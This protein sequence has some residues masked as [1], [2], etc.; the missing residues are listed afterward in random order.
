MPDII[1]M[2]P[3]GRAGRLSSGEM[4]WQQQLSQFQGAA[5]LMSKNLARHQQMGEAKLKQAN[6]EAKLA[7]Q[8][9]QD[10]LAGDMYLDIA[11]QRAQMTPQQQESETFFKT[12][13]HIKDPKLRK[14]LTDEHY[15]LQKQKQYMQAAE[16]GVALLNA[17]IQDGYISESDG[18]RILTE[19]EAKVSKGLDISATLDEID[20]LKKKAVSSIRQERAWS[21][22]G[23]AMRQLVDRMP[24]GPEKEA[25]DER[26]TAIENFPS[27]RTKIDPET[28]IVEM[29]AGGQRG[30]TMKESTGSFG[31]PGL[32]VMNSLSAIGEM[33]EYVTKSGI[34]A[35]RPNLPKNL[36]G[37][38]RLPNKITF[39]Q[40]EEAIK[41]A[42]GL[43]EGRKDKKQKDARKNSAFRGTNF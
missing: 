9:S 12:V 5:E 11:R 25:A 24:D 27:E 6:A 2:G 8:A 32:G 20:V 37:K 43:K 34:K 16:H 17:G 29:G 30:E 23:P 39:E 7:E 10:K 1:F 18:E 40:E 28:F 31:D 36:T 41:E 15:Q 22:A 4:T 42:L 35:P 13:E 33:S 26:L 3:G 19:F 21:D 38:S 14:D